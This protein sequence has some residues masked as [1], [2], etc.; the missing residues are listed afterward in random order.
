MLR[1]PSVRAEQSRLL[2][3]ALRAGLSLDRWS[4]GVQD[5]LAKTQ[6]Y[7]RADAPGPD[8]HCL[9]HAAY[10]PIVQ[11]LAL[12][13]DRQPIGVPRDLRS[14]PITLLHW[15]ILQSLPAN[16]DRRRCGTRHDAGTVQR[17][18]L[19]CAGQCDRGPFGRRHSHVDDGLCGNTRPTG[20]IARM[21]ADPALGHH[22]LPVS[23][24]ALLPK[25]SGYSRKI[26]ALVE[27][28]GWSRG[29][30]GIW[31]KAIGLSFIVQGLATLQVIL[32]GIALD[33]SVAWYA[34]LVVVPLVSLL[35][36]LPLSFNGI[37]VREYSLILLL[38]PFGVSQEQATAL[39]LGWFAL[40]IGVG[41][42]GGLVYLFSDR[43]TVPAATDLSD[44]G[45]DGHESVNRRTDDEREG[46]RQAAA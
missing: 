31:W 6:A 45:K 30:W 46:Q 11:Q 2:K 28:L 4:A 29:R 1:L 16:F 37:G 36:M 23:P 21:D 40:T 24:M 25:L 27:A 7:V 9:C 22:R 26:Q 39:G 34:Y 15:H 44:E 10:R 19:G 13:D 18:T 5:R 12:E 3:F 41:L 42:V 8:R 17:S 38:A 14:F 33:L 32:L 43:S 35:T 20:S